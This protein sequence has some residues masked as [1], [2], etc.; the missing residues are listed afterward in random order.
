M[1]SKFPSSSTVTPASATTKTPGGCAPRNPWLPRIRP[2]TDREP[3]ASHIAA[4]TLTQLISKLESR[5]IAGVC[6]EDTLFPKTDSL[7]LGGEIQPLADIHE[8]C[9]KIMAC[10]DT[11]KDSDFNVVARLEAFITGHGLDEALK[12]AE[13]YHKAGAD[14]IL[15]HSKMAVSHG[16]CIP[17]LPRCGWQLLY[18]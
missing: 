5:G 16:C 10:K 13:A 12:R 15:C 14:A 11:Q 1:R 7:N 9:G 8:F 3:L 17:L 6:L 2:P 4:A 18:P